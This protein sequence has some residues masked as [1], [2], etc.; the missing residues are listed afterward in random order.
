MRLRVNRGVTQQELAEA[1]G[2]TVQTVRNWERGRSI[3]HLTIGQVKTLL[4]V[5]Q[6]EIGDLP[7][8]FGP[9]DGSASALQY[10]RERAGL[11][12]EELAKRIAVKGSPIAADLVRQWEEGDLVPELSIFQVAAIC[13]ELGITAKQLATCFSENDV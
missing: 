11:S 12:R 13:E 5:L 8:D 3:P 2:V 7:E 1:L 9:Q 6:V 4:R 10:L